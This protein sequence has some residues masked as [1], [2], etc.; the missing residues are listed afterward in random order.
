MKRDKSA[1]GRRGLEHS[2]RLLA[3]SYV[4]PSAEDLAARV[5]ACSRESAPNCSDVVK[6]EHSLTLSVLAFTE[7]LSR[8]LERLRAAAPEVASW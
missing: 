4:G 8:E 2:R 3:R 6:P 1:L 5:C 7:P